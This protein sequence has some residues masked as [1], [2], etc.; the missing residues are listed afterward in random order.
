MANSFSFVGGG[1]SANYKKLTPNATYWSGETLTQEDLTRVK[2]T[3]Y[4]HARPCDYFISHDTIPVFNQLISIIP[5][6][7]VK[8]K[9]PMDYNHRQYLKRN[10]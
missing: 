1:F 3:L 6:W 5:K 10:V 2:D 8:W 4:E 7:F 9:W